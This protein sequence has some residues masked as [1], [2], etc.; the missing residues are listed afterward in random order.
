MAGMRREDSHYR[1]WKLAVVVGSRRN[2]TVVGHGVRAAPPHTVIMAEGYGPELVLADLRRQVDEIEA[3]L[4]GRGAAGPRGHGPSAPTPF[5]PA[6]PEP[7]APSV[8]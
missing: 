1:G 5:G 3:G 2:R 8:P 6:G 7:Q 4:E